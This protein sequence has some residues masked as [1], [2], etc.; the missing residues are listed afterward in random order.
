MN[1]CSYVH[2]FI[3]AWLHIFI[4]VWVCVCVCVCVCVHIFTCMR[5]FLE[6]SPAIKFLVHTLVPCTK[7]YFL[8]ISNSGRKLQCQIRVTSFI[9]LAFAKK[10]TKPQPESYKAVEYY[11]R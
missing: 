9:N 11:N 1:V 8:R 4:H 5:V 6:T 2:T 10:C 7:L 3:H